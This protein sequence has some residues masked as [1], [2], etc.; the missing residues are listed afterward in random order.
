MPFCLEAP[1]KTTTTTSFAPA[2][3]AATIGRL[4]IVQRTPLYFGI[5][6]NRPLLYELP[7][8]APEII[9][10]DGQYYIASMRTEYDGLRIA[11][12]KW[13]TLKERQKIRFLGYRGVF[14]FDNKASHQQWGMVEGNLAPIF[15]TSARKYFDSR[16][17]YFIGTGRKCT[18]QPG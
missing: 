5:D 2:A 9:L 16:Y 1:P 15:T 14:N 7:V 17:V 18:T 8:A 10:D 11:K 4:S 6:D 13:V 12:L 3:P